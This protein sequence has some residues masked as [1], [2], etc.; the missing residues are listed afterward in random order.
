MNPLLPAVAI[1]VIGHAL[2]LWAYWGDRHG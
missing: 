2:A 1:I